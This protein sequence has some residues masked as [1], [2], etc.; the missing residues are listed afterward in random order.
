VPASLLSW[1][2]V[3]TGGP[4]PAGSSFRSRLMYRATTE[5]M[6][7]ACLEATA[8]EW[9]ATQ[10]YH[11]I[12]TTE[13]AQSSYRLGT[14][15]A[16]VA[17]D[18]ALGVPLLV[19]RETLFGKS[20]G[21]RGDLLGFRPAT[22]DWHGV[23]A[24]GK[25]PGWP[26]GELRYVSPRDFD[27]AKDQAQSLGLDLVAASLPTGVGDHW[28]V[29]SRAS[30]RMP[31]EIVLDDPVAEGEGPP[32]RAVGPDFH[33]DDPFERLLQ[34]YYQVVGDIEALIAV[35]APEQP[36]RFGDEYVGAL[37]PGTNLWVGARHDLFVARRA[38]Q[39]REI[40]DVLAEANRLVDDFG[41]ASMGLAVDRL[42]PAAFA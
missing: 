9:R 32:P 36:S 42:A 25:S 35:D 4:L 19:H 1:H 17:S 12:E 5:A 23:E 37:L 2:A 31:L 15:F 30:T 20:S 14:T 22:H 13:K 10:L 41:Y 3:Y 29:T 28:A 18:V 38:G 34:G 26:T 33:Q 40:V 27:S 11:Q 21:Q 24:K 39:L 6:L 16:G 7:W 8:G